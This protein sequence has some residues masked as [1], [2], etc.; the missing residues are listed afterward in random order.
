MSDDFIRETNN[1]ERWM[2]EEMRRDNDRRREQI[3]TRI[4]YILSALVGIVVVVTVVGALAPAIS[5]WTPPSASNAALVAL[6]AAIDYLQALG[7]DA[8]ADYEHQLLQYATGRALHI[9]GL[10]IIGTALVETGSKMDDVIFA[11]TAKRPALGRAEVALTIDNTSGML[12][13]DF[14][15]V[16]ITRTLFRSGDSEYAINKTP[17]RLLDIQEL[18]FTNAYAFPGVTL[19]ADDYP[20]QVLEKMA[21]RLVEHPEKKKQSTIISFL[22]H[23]EERSL[24]LS[25]QFSSSSS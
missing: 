6:G 21:A 5:V 3:N 15:E 4:G 12:P 8:I 24:L 9:P 25:Y 2:A 11:G 19:I 14:T 16:T 13:L 22:S 7:M 18:L 17:C 10:T 1:H 23:H 20:A